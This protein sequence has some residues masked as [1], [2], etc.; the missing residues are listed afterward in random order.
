MELI[1]A[2]PR[3]FCF[4]VRRAISTLEDSLARFGKVYALGS[5]IHNS[6]EINRL[7]SLGLEIIEDPS[8]VP[9]KAAVFIRAHG[10]SGET[11]ESLA[12]KGSIIIDGTCP[13]VRKAQEKAAF[14]S[15]AGYMVLILGDKDHPEVQ[16]IRQFARGMVRVVDPAAVSFPVESGISKIGIVSQ[17]TQRKET[18]SLLVSSVT[19]MADEVR[20]F[21]TIC[22]ATSARQESVARLAGSVDGIIVIGGKNSANTAKLV[23][24]SKKTGTPTLWIENDG[25]MESGWFRGKR[26]IGIAAGASTP[27]WL[28][29]KLENRLASAKSAREDGYEDD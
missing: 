1:F 13:F 16:A 27:D 20:V 19:K 2:E 22:D 8:D 26:K 14:L 5:P 17:T 11:L 25:E 21:N 10:V 18:L 9:S 12:G 24:I 6:Q 4:G 15:E 3:G 7:R 28:I 23:E 29:H